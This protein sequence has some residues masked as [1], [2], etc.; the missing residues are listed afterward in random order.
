MTTILLFHHVQG[1]TPGVAAI[2]DTFRA[3]GHTVHVPD[4]LDGKTFGSIPEGIAYVKT[5]GFGEVIARGKAA[6]DA[7][8][9]PIVVIGM[10][11]GVLPAQAIAQTRG[12]VCGVVLL[13]GAVDVTEF[14][15]VWP[16]QVPVQVHAMDADPEFV[17]SG[18]TDA[19]MELVGQSD[20]GDLFLYP[21]N[22]H[23]FTDNSVA[24]YDAEQAALVMSRV[25]AFLDEV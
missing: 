5:I 10:S 13:H 15:P 3:A 22:G 16:K 9:G 4:L 2:A 6:A 24:D 8:A 20:N 17:D 7:V 11:L 23:L 18:D 12:D 14:S 19:A 1:L 21:G 25:L